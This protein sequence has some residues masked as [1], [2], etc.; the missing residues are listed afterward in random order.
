MRSFALR[1]IG[2]GIVSLIV[3]VGFIPSWERALA[4]RGWIADQY[5]FGDLYNMTNIARFKEHTFKETDQLDSTDL[6][7]VKEAGV[8]LYTIGDSFTDI[9][10]AFYPAEKNVHVWIGNGRQAIKLDSTKRNVLVIQIIERVLQERFRDHS[11]QLYATNALVDSSR[12]KPPAPKPTTWVGNLLNTR[13]GSDLN[14]RLEFMLFNNNIALKAKELK[15]GFMLDWFDRTA[16]ARLSANKQH[17]FYDAETDTT[18]QLSSFRHI[19]EQDIDAVV[20]HLNY[21]T[22]YYRKLGFQEIYLTL[23]P[24]KSTV[25]A[26]TLGV[27]NHQI[28]RIERHPDLQPTVISTINTIRQHPDWYHLGDGHWNKQGRRYWLGIVNNLVRTPT[29][30]MADR[31]TT[32]GLDKQTGR[33]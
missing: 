15:A 17:A 9:D 10:T 3:L 11:W 12:I 14:S 20:K 7:A 30:L 18:Q 19:R 5:R 31:G 32:T 8:H 22:D 6:P 28:E 13:F 29:C 26:P 4:R 23:I 25:L 24:N 1:W 27:Y 21:V 16:G 2:I 33:Q